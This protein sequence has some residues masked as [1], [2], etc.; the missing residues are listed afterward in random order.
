M[1]KKAQ[2]EKKSL[3]VLRFASFSEHL[4][5]AG[6]A[7]VML[8][9]IDFTKMHFMYIRDRRREFYRRLK[10]P[11][12][13]LFMEGMAALSLSASMVPFL[14][15]QA[16]TI[17]VTFV[18]QPDWTRKQFDSIWFQICDNENGDD[19]EKPPNGIISPTA[20][21]L[22]LEGIKRFCMELK[23]ENIR[24]PSFMLG[25]A[26]VDRCDTVQ[27]MLRA[28]HRGVLVYPSIETHAGNIAAGLFQHTN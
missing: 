1:G 27:E 23:A 6:I 7:M 2:Y 25:Q 20:L 17:G 26:L 18:T 14:G 16:L 12:S 19:C 5:T 21:P 4:P 8:G 3:E 15:G 28:D 13:D 10:D 9:W 24:I 22:A 11:A